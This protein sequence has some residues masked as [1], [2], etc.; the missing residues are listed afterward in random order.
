VLSKGAA[1]G[2]ALNGGVR[3]R[4]CSGRR[5]VGPPH[6]TWVAIDRH[7]ILLMA[8]RDAARDVHGWPKK[9]TKQCRGDPSQ[10]AQVFTLAAAGFWLH[11]GVP[12]DDLTGLR[13]Y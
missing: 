1:H 2:F 6:L 8:P 7:L 5:L 9:H 4:R 13:L 11:D 10:N 12:Y 3:L